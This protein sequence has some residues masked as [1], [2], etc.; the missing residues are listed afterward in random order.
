MSSTVARTP[1][2]RT[3]RLVALPAEHGGWG[4]V[5]EPILLGWCVAPAPAGLWL[6]LATLAVFLVRQPLK[7]ALTDRR[8]GKRYPRTAWAERFVLGYGIVAGAALALALFTARAPF[9]A[10]IALAAPL[11]LL[12]A[13]YDLQ[14]QSRQLA[15]ELAG[16]LA[17]GAGA[18]AIAQAGGW[19]LGPALALWAVLAVRA[20]PS[21]LYVRARLRLERGEAVDRRPALVAHGLGLALVAGLALA[22]A[23]PWLAVLAV[24]VLAGRAAWGLAARR[25]V[26]AQVVGF[27]EIGFG[28]LVVVL[29]A[30]GY[31]LGL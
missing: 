5:L 21:I 4:F 2:G 11:A 6:G 10:P 7:L 15:A 28:L 18:A 29:T 27:E 8:A 1:T 23:A 9:W 17:L 16:A 26:R 20:A 31:G 13:Y 30:L 19:S 12:Q 14:R 22:G 24:G 25:G 3:L